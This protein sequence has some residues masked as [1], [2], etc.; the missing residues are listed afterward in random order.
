M[1]KPDINM[2]NFLSI[3]GDAAFAPDDA[4]CSIASLPRSSLLISGVAAGD[5]CRRCGGV[6]CLE[7]EEPDTGFC[8]EEEDADA[9]LRLGEEEAGT[10]FG[11]GG[12]GAG[13]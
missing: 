11:L 13:R 7:G 2:V 9:G 10:G 6:L 4:A 5:A 3:P 12:A 8:L 1:N